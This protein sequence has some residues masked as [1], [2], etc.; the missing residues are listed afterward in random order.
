M[1]NVAKREWLCSCE[2]VG[3]IG[4][5][6]LLEV[7]NFWCVICSLAFFF[8]AFLCVRSRFVFVVNDYYCSAVVCHLRT[9]TVCMRHLQVSAL[10]CVSG[11]DCKVGN[12]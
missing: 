5:F 4:K 11:E 2:K 9:S 3:L 1:N 12:G 10:V 6:E 7:A 8:A